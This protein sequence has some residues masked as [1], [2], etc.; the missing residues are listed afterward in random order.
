[1]KT[2]GAGAKRIDTAC[3]VCVLC[4]GLS[5]AQK[6]D[7]LV[8]NGVRLV[9]NAKDP[10]PHNG[11]ILKPTLTEDLVIGGGGSIEESSFARLTFICIDDE[12]DIIALD[13]KDM[14][15]KVFDKSG[16]FVRR[17]GRRGQGPDEI[18]TPRGMMLWGGKD[19]VILD[20][21]NNRL[22]FYSKDGL[23]I[24]SVSLKGTQ[25]Y[26][27]VMDSG[28]NCYGSALEFSAKVGLKL[29][30]FDPEFNP[31]STVSSLEM[32]KENEIPPPELMEQFVFQ[33]GEKSSLIWGV[34]SKYELNFT[35][36]D[37]RLFKRVSRAAVPEK[38]TRDLLAMEMRKRNPDRPIPASLKVPPHYPKHF[39]FFSALI[40]DDE[41]RV[42]VRT[43]EGF[44]SGHASY[45]VFDQEGIYIARFK[46]P[47]NEEIVAV[48]KAKVYSRI[49]ENEDGIPIIKRYRIAW[50]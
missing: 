24:K 12:E 49:R 19:I 9:K 1:M 46:W 10:V 17:F 44:G 2:I 11:M 29:L 5:A 22:S 50:K 39:P 37:G 31:V 7:F 35:D 23:C 6:A 36:S 28:G 33:I 4:I 38:V 41:G 42:F 40:S 20:S 14:C 8:E 18:Q 15:L 32:P 43:L 45:D 48:K 26:T 13:G 34:N 21:G 16:R 30:K 47:E 27:P 25:P 3:F